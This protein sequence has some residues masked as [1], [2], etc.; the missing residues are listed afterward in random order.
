VAVDIFSV[1]SS[2]LD[3]LSQRHA[4]AAANVANADTP[5]F[6]SK[7]IANFDLAL[8]E[9]NDAGMAQTSPGHMTADPAQASKY[10]VAFQNNAEASL[11]GND[12]TLEKE[13]ATIGDS[14]RMF[15]FD[16]ALERTFQRMFISSVKG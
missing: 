7:Q 1:L 5:G 6:K 16:T 2:H 13:M 8:S 15:A 11:S 9:A 10:E 12:V 4:I 14:S 3:W